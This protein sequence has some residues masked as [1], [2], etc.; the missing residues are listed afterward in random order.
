MVH[1]TI[2]K[3]REKNAELIEL[4]KTL[5][6]NNIKLIG[7]N[8]AIKIELEGTKTAK[9]E[10]KKKCEIIIHQKDEEIFKREAKLRA[11]KPIKSHLDAAN[12]TRRVNEIPGGIEIVNT[13]KYAP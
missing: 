7:E 2:L 6:D 3:L 10:C 4:N 12:W 8:K 13:I 9:D 1:K 11:L 5:L